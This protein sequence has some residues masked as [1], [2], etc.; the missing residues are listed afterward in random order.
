MKSINQIGQ[1]LVKSFGQENI[2]DNSRTVALPARQVPLDTTGI[3]K[4]DLALAKCVREYQKPRY[5]SK[6]LTDKHG[7]IY[8]HEF[9][10]VG[11][12]PQLEIQAPLDQ[13]L[14]EAIQ[15]PAPN[16]HIVYHLTRLAAH[17]HD[18]R[19]IV[20]AAVFEDIANDLRG[21]SEWAVILACR[22]LR[23]EKD[24]IY[25]P[26]T[27]QILDTTRRHQRQIDRIV[28]ESEEKRGN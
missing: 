10:I 19:G 17:L 15:R 5:G 25:F 21:I 2:G 26:T 7:N 13:R 20:S 27:G 16:T 4:I 3:E 22:E 12:E 11:Y 18:T 28:K 9:D 23:A 8:R 1:D 24:R 6:P 14:L